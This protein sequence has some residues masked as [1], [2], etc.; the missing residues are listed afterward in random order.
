VKALDLLR[1][2]IEAHRHIALGVRDQNRRR[3]GAGQRN[4]LEHG[5]A[6]ARAE[7]TQRVVGALVVRVGG[8]NHKRREIGRRR[9]GRHDDDVHVAALEADEQVRFAGRV[10]ERR[11]VAHELVGEDGR[12]ARR[13]GREVE[14]LEHAAARH[15]EQGGVGEHEEARDA[16]ARRGDN[17]AHGGVVRGDPHGAVECGEREQ[18]LHGVER[19]GSRHSGRNER[20]GGGRRGAA[21]VEQMRIARRVARRRR[22]A[23]VVGCG[24]RRRLAVF[25]FGR[26]DGFQFRKH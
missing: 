4:Q 10:A 3:T 23:G 24:G 6:A 26:E 13:C 1:R 25:V 14:Q 9:V 11:D 5:R 7:R 22:R 16:L 19:R 15:G 18:L 2:D 12:V 8:R 17:A 20:G 21:Q